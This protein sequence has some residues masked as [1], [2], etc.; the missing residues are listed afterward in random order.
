MTVEDTIAKMI[1]NWPSLYRDR[2]S[3]L[4]RIFNDAD[5][6][7][8][9]PF[10]ESIS[11]RD[12]NIF[13]DVI[14]AV[15][16]FDQSDSPYAKNKRLE[17]RLRTFRENATLK[18]IIDNASLIAQVKSHEFSYTPSFSSYELNRIPLEKLAPEWRE[19]LI[20]FCEEILIESEKNVLH[21]TAQYPT[22]DIQREIKKLEQA[23]AT[24]RECL[25]RIDPSRAA[26]QEATERLDAI[27]KLQYEAEKFGYTLTKM[28]KQQ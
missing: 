16:R 4:T 18:F 3:A 12:E 24:A 28:D 19:A 22:A 10:S 1:Q 7:D 6:H 27:R 9:Q 8:G 23:Q 21:R 25:V 5:W 26:A 17:I 20:E 15:A 11:T 2:L 14:T 13:E